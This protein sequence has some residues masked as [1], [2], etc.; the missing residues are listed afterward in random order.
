M[1]GIKTK[2]TR[3]QR[4]TRSLFNLAFIAVLSGSTLAGSTWILGHG[5][6]LV[7]HIIR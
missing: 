2:P 5:V 7:H 3:V 6:T 4:V 1:T